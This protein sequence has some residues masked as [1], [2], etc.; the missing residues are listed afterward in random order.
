[1]EH[2]DIL[3]TLV[4]GYDPD[5]GKKLELYINELHRSD[6]QFNLTGLTSIRDIKSTLINGS[7]RPLGK[8]IVPR[9]TMVADMGAG[10]GIPGI[11]LSICR[12]DLAVTLMESNEKR[13]TF[14]KRIRRMIAGTYE[15]VEGRIEELAHNLRQR[16]KYSLVVSRAFAP[17]YVAL[18]CGASLL[19]NN[20]LLYIYS[21]SN[22][23]SLPKAV[24]AHAEMLG[25]GRLDPEQ[26]KN[27]EFPGYG[28]LF[29]KKAITPDIFPRR[30]AVMKRE[31]GRLNGEL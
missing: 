3:S 23:G 8:I 30:F 31:A 26:K 7:L 29:Q 2:P 13:I 4:H 19:S 22:E 17:P 21:E 9:G 11:P 16:G 12:P 14:L 18:E 27:L 24:L 20:G 28:Y 6:K 1:M 10:Q 5:M 15:I 25:L